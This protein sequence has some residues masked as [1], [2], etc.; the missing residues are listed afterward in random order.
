MFFP[1]C[2]VLPLEIIALRLFLP[3]C[4]YSVALLPVQSPN[5]KNMV[6]AGKKLRMENFEQLLRIS[7]R[8]ML[9]NQTEKMLADTLRG[10]I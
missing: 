7:Q 5:S 9:S 3:K 6:P 8:Y 4:P 2:T 1:T 10:V